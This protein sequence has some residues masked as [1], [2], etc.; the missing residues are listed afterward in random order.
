MMNVHLGLLLCYIIY[1]LDRLAALRFLLAA[2]PGPD[3]EGG[4]TCE[5]CPELV[6][7]ETV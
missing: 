1:S 7:C 6:N 4:P 5:E 2:T 3:T